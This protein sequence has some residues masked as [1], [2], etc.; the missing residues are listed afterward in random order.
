[1]N[2]LL[3]SL[4]PWPNVATSAPVTRAEVGRLAAAATERHSERVS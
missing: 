4:F 1:M 3:A 2:R